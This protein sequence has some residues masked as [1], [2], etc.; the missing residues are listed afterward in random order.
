MVLFKNVYQIG[1]GSICHQNMMD[2]HAAPQSHP[3]M[4]FSI[5][6]GGTHIKPSESIAQEQTRK[7]KKYRISI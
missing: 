2:C 3:Y 6:S 7:K 4:I 1:F 5:S